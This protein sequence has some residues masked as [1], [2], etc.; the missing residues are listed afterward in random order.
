[1]VKKLLLI[2]INFFLKLCISVQKLIMYYCENNFL[3]LYFLETLGATGEPRTYHVSRTKKNV[4]FAI[5]QFLTVC[6]I[7]IYFKIRQLVFFNLTILLKKEKIII[8]P[9]VLFYIILHSFY[10]FL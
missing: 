10:T 2:I 9:Y 6:A 3:L 8:F 1:M 5:N 4:I 7:L